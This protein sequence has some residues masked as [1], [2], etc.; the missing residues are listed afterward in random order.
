MR[1]F[2]VWVLQALKN[3]P[4]KRYFAWGGVLVITVQLKQ[5]NFRQQKSFRG[6]VDIP[7]MC[8]MYMSFDGGYTIWAL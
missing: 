2:H 5:H 8:I 3:C 6:L 1:N 7:R 4:R